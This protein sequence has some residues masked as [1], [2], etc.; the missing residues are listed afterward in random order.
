MYKRQDLLAW[1]IGTGG[2]TV[3]HNGDIYD[4]G[5]IVGF[6]PFG[7]SAMGDIS[8][9]LRVGPR[10]QSQQPDYGFGFMDFMSLMGI[11]AL[12]NNMRFMGSGGSIPSYRNSGFVREDPY[13]DPEG[14]ALYLGKYKKQQYDRSALGRASAISGAIYDDIASVFG[15]FGDILVPDFLNPFGE[16]ASIQGI[17]KSVFYDIP[18]GIYDFA[19]ESVPN[20]FSSVFGIGGEKSRRARASHEGFFGFG[21]GGAIPSFRYGGVG[22]SGY[23]YDGELIKTKFGTNRKAT[24]S[25]YVDDRTVFKNIFGRENK[26]G[27]LLVK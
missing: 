18:L 3:K 9:S 23:D 21:Q 26:S 14:A 1:H 11:F 6:D 5:G 4:E 15:F 19:T 20:Y 10:Y 7:V 13:L 8:T 16:E 2:T 24:R 27:S 25:K 22:G 17:L 12:L